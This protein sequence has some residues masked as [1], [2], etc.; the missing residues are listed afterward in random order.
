MLVHL[1]GILFPPPPHPPPPSIFG[2]LHNFFNFEWYRGWRPN[3]KKGLNLVVLETL[4]LMANRQGAIDEVI[5]A[6]SRFQPWAY[7]GML[8]KRKDITFWAFLHQKNNKIADKGQYKNVRG[9]NFTRIFSLLL[10]IILSIV[11][12]FINKLATNCFQRVFPIVE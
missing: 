8:N 9:P 12:E 6:V 11:H 10:L 3:I 7:W 1:P 4:V 5:P 2:L